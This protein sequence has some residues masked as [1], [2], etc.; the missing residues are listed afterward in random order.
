MKNTHNTRGKS[1]RAMVQKGYLKKTATVLFLTGS[2]LSGISTTHAAETYWTGE[3]DDD[4]W[5]NAD[6]W[7]S[8][9]P[10]Y[11]YAAV[12]NNIGAVADDTTDS[13]ILYLRIGYSK[14]TA[15]TGELTIDGANITTRDF[16]ISYIGRHSGSSAT[17][18]MISG[19]LTFADTTYIANEGSSGTVNQDGGLISFQHDSTDADDATAY[20]TSVTMGSTNGTAEYNF[21][22]GTLETRAAFKL[23]TAGTGTTVFSVIGYDAGSSITIGGTSDYYDDGAWLQGSGTTLSVSIDGDTTEGSTLIEI[24]LGDNGDENANDGTAVFELGS[25]LYIDFNS[26]AQSGTWTILYAEGGIVDNG[27]TFADDVDTDIW[28][29]AIVG[30]ELQVTATVVVPEPSTFALILGGCALLTVGR[31]RRVR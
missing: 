15:Q 11:S 1:K 21:T 22:S 25:L 8:S 24:L 23:T 29:F 17:L 13:T 9:M 20:S 18:N 16:N 6:N 19:S 14:T 28:S 31:R 5:S 27:L 10:G 12:I 3:G 30:N 7:S 26:E 2:L 4:L